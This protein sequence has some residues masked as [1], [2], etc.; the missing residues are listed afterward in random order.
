MAALLAIGWE[1]ELRG[2]LITIIAVFVFMG[3]IY[4]I[5][6]TNLG[7]PPRLPRG[8]RRARRMAVPHGRDVVDVR[9]GP[10]RTR[11]IVGPRQRA[12][13]CL[14]TDTLTD[15][16]PARRPGGRRRQR[17]PDHHR[18]S[19][20]RSVRQRGLEAARSLGAVVPTGRRCGQRAARG[21]GGVGQ[22]RVPGRQRVRQ[23]R[24]TLARNCSTAGSTSWRSATRRTTRGR[25]RAAGRNS[26]TNRVERPP[27]RRSTPLVPRQYVYMIR[28]LGAK[29]KPAGFITVGSLTVFLMLCYL[30]HTRDRVVLENRARRGVARADVATPIHSGTGR[31][32]GSVPAGRVP[33][34]TGYVVRRAQLLRV[35][36]A[37]AAS[38][39]VGEVGAVRV[40]H[41][42]Q[43]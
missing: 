7:R 30:L 26:A 15:S 4:L 39:V 21:I 38:A 32:D 37:C 2:I 17:R 23:G 10:A 5:L 3:S 34:G 14:T 9:Q 43:S 41:R 1:P 24:R 31:P 20:H 29:R 8:L 6:S 33:V 25:G 36:P 13:P 27:N 40:R 18:R 11:R 28:D 12:A 35:A 22:R 16:G 19:G 42:A